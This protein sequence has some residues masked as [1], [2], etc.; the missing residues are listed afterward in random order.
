MDAK[1]LTGIVRGAGV[2]ELRADHPS[3]TYRLVCAT[4]LPGAV[5]VLH[6]F[7]KKSKRG[8]R[9]PKREMDLIRRRLKRARLDSERRTNE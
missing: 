9:T 2:L 8:I 4:S 1:P 7:Q 6:A 5:Y 3:G